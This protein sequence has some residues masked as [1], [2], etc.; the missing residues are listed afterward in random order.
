MPHRFK[1]SRT[2]L[3]ND[4]GDILSLVSFYGFLAIFFQYA[5]QN[6]SLMLVTTPI[7]LVLGGAGLMIVGRVVTIRSWAKDGIQPNEYAQV[8]SIVFGIS[9][10]VLGVLLWVGASLPVS[11]QGWVGLFALPP[12]V[13][14]AIHY[15]LKNKYGVC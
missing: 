1:Q 14:I 6:E 4:F 15:Y 2:M 10:I 12:L 5:L 8:F 3:P 9:S 13:F 11:I 7:F